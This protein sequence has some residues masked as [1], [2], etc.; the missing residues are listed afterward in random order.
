[1]IANVR[2][3]F[4]VV[5]LLALAVPAQAASCRPIPSGTR[6]NSICMRMWGMIR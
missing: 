4:S 6:I 2:N 3:A 5:A 1:M